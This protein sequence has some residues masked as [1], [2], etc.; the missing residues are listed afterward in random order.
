MLYNQNFLRE[1]TLAIFYFDRFPGMF[2]RFSRC[3]YFKLFFDIVI[4]HIGPWA[5]TFF[6]FIVAQKIIR[7]FSNL[8]VSTFYNFQ[9]QIWK[10]L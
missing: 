7:T 8:K 4:Y 9:M 10:L 6:G 2:W 1:L 5:D 3:W